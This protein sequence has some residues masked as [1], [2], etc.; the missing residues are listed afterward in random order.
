MTIHEA[1]VVWV[2]YCFLFSGCVICKQSE[3][4]TGKETE[5]E[6]SLNVADSLPENDSEG[7]SARDQPDTEGGKDE[8]A[9]KIN[10]NGSATN[11]MNKASTGKKEG[12]KK[13]PKKGKKEGKKEKGTK[14]GR[15]SDGTNRYCMACRQRDCWFHFAPPRLVY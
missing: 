2:K 8:I 13:K 1:L 12:K 3:Q 10:K 11:L 4:V 7:D 6:E 15:K 5:K 9:S 14:A